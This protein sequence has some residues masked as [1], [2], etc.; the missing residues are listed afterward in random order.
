MVV[1]VDYVQYDYIFILGVNFSFEYDVWIE[2]YNEVNF[3]KWLLKYKKEIKNQG[4][5]NLELVLLMYFGVE[6]FF[7]I[8]F[9]FF[10][11]GYW[12]W[13]FLLLKVWK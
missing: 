5:W 6:Q 11:V 10:I 9:V 12:V 1:E 8:L 2:M 3:F 13:I 7:D 4:V